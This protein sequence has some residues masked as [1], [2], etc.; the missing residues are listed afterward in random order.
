MNPYYIMIF[1]AVVFLAL[2]FTMNKAYQTKMGSGFKASLIFLTF[3]SL[4]ATILLFGFGWI[5]YGEMINITPFSLALG[6]GVGVL[7]FA[8][9]VIGF[10]IFKFGSL[11]IFT[12]FLMLGG[13]VLPYLFGLIWL[14]EKISPFKIIGMIL[15]VVSLIFPLLG[16]RREKKSA[17]KIGIFVTLCMLVFVA[18]GFVSILSKVQSTD[19]LFGELERIK[20]VYFPVLTN[21]VDFLLSGILLIICT[22]SETVKKKKNNVQG[23][24][25][26]TA[27]EEKKPAPVGLIMLFMTLCALFSGA[28]YA[29]QLF[30]AGQVD[31][32]VMYPMQTGGSIILTAIA[33]LVF[34]KEKPNK[35]TIIGLCVTFAST[36]LFLF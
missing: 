30:S 32:S 29:L 16:Q 13:T 23:T 3:K 20:T 35:L 22:I 26:P 11:G 24:D 34:F 36:F 15:L 17:G 9:N 8:Y 1:V 31:A 19:L 10:Q 25:K 4:F 12:T 28:S 21:G 33:G 18:N 2:Q 7:C 6:A 14:D 5:Y 27:T